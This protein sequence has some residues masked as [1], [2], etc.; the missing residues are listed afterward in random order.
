[1]LSVGGPS[2]K[3]CALCRWVFPRIFA[4]RLFHSE[5]GCH[6][7]KRTRCHFSPHMSLK[8]DGFKASYCSTLTPF[9]AHAGV[10]RYLVWQWQDLSRRYQQ[11]GRFPTGNRPQTPRK[12]GGLMFRLRNRLPYRRSSRSAAVPSAWG[13]CCAGW[14]RCRRRLRQARPPGAAFC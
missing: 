9:S 14:S 4:V 12:M 8:N 3:A 7:K 6:S 11:S 10:Y 2:A 1:M 13:L 5:R